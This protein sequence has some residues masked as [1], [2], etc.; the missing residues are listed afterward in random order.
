MN[1]KALTGLFAVGIGVVA[2]PVVLIL[3]LVVLVV[4]GVLWPAAHPVGAPDWARP[5]LWESDLLNHDGST[6]DQLGLA[7]MSANDGG[8][9]LADGGNM[10]LAGSSA[11]DSVPQA[12]VDLSALMVRDNHNYDRV[13]TDYINRYSVWRDLKPAQRQAKINQ[14]INAF[15]GYANGDWAMAAFD[16]SD[17]FY[18]NP[19]NSSG[20][21]YYKAGSS[22][23]IFVVAG[24]PVGAK[25][26][27]TLGNSL[28]G[29]RIVQPDSV[30]LYLPWLVDPKTGR[31]IPVNMFPV[32]GTWNQFGDLILWP[33]MTVWEADVSPPKA[34]RYTITATATWSSTLEGQDNSISGSSAVDIQ[35]TGGGGGTGIIVPIGGWNPSAGVA[36]WSG[37]VAQAVAKYPTSAIPG[38]DENALVAAII[39]A[40][41]SGNPGAISSAGAEG[42]M[43]VEPG[44][45]AGYGVYGAALWDPQTNIDVGTD[46]LV[47]LV[48]EFRR[49]DYAAAAYNAGPGA[50]I[51]HGGIPPYPETVNYVAKVEAGYDYWKAHGF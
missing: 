4:G 11:E 36:Q 39:D 28:D 16:T 50:V 14:V 33:G 18:D 2:V 30:E 17:P 3:S 42:L 6:P 20:H 48:N 27:I 10:A 38:L 35:F 29:A 9:P 47:S 41:S 49:I 44:T 23:K 8:N 15:D 26:F 13:L 43:Q 22:A 1:R 37:Q 21:P 51:K 24:A 46:Y 7:I 45:A 25:H 12:A 5:Y 19:Q 40:E 32:T 34:G 31:P